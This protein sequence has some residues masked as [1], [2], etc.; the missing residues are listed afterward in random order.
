MDWF[1]TVKNFY[2]SGLYTKDQ[3]KVFVV[4]GKITPEQYE[5]ITGDTY[6]P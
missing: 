2:D 3:V 5:Q 6:T 1:Q 4:K